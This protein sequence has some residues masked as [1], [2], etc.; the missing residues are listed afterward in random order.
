MNRDEL[1]A[2]LRAGIEAARNN[3]IILART[4][5]QQ[6]LDE[7]PD[8]ELA[9]M[10]MAQV[11][12]TDDQRRRALQEVL[13]INPDNERARQALTRLGGTA[14]SREVDRPS[15]LRARTGAGATPA[16]QPDRP[17][18]LPER[19]RDQP[20]ELWRSGRR[21][22][23]NTGLIFTL[24]LALV[25]V[26]LII[27]GLVLLI[28]RIAAD[29]DEI[30]SSTPD[31]TAQAAQTTSPTPTAIPQPT[32][33]PIDIEGIVISPVPPTN[34]PV[35]TPSPTDT[36]TVTPS[37]VPPDGDY[38]L[39]VA[40]NDGALYTMRSDGSG[41]SRL[42][43]AV[44]DG[45][46][47]QLSS[48]AV[49]PDGRSVVFTAEIN[50]V[51]E[52]YVGS[53]SNPSDVFQLTSLGA[54]GTSDAAWSPDSEQIAFA[55]NA[56]GHYALYVIPANGGEPRQITRD[57]QRDDRDPSWSSDGRFLAYSSITSRGFDREVY[58]I[59]P[60][61][62]SNEFCQLTEAPRLSLKPRWSPNGQRIAFL[63]DRSGD[64]GEND[65]FLMQADGTG[66]TML[67][68]S[69]GDAHETALDWSPDGKF[70]AVV[71]TRQVANPDTPTPTP[72]DAGAPADE[73]RVWLLDVESNTWYPVADFDAQAVTFIGERQ[74]SEPLAYQCS[75][76]RSN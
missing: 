37:P 13:R 16:R 51:Q 48:P 61:L 11:V 62:L 59:E 19:R 71:S 1:N 25:A 72:A 8:N 45:A 9:W 49:S 30:I 70:L 69:D 65:L 44:G 52:L 29:E 42:N 46:T 67:T 68:V 18:A 55:S 73:P 39:L 20:P 6:V 64:P 40:G 17:A 66:E 22:Q 60:R 15:G 57:P 23:D 7:D 28:D 58:V 35:D 54:S 5:F 4:S 2:T 27:V 21:Q 34:T 47:A 38:T 74:L 10:W 32:N 24:G 50:G 31:E 76:L 12:D 36:P 43:Y 75:A 63:S 26:V 53:L 33:T 56:S 41:R 3:N 14:P